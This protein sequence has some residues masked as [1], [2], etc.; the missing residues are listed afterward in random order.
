M[1]VKVYAVYDNKSLVYKQTFTATA[2]G[3]A[4]RSFMTAVNSPN[5]ALH[6]YPEDFE[7]YE[8]AE[9]DDVTAE[10]TNQAPLLL[11]RGSEFTKGKTNE[12]QN[13]EQQT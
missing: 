3:E 4:L 8:I 5:T 10:Y 1:K 2:R 7:L 6:D 11:G 9:Y 12:I 13:S